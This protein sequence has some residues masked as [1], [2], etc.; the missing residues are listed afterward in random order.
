MRYKSSH[1]D[2]T[3]SQCGKCFNRSSGLHSHAK[4]NHSK[5]PY[6]CIGPIRPHKAPFSCIRKY[7]V[8]YLRFVQTDPAFWSHITLFFETGSQSG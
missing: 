7:F 3:F 5:A 4:N 6:S 8:T 2:K 1:C